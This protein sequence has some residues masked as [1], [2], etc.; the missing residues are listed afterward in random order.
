MRY[1]SWGL[2]REGFYWLWT[3]VLVIAV[4]LF[5]SINLLTLLGYVLL[6]IIALNALV[7]GRRLRSLQVR[8]RIGEPVFAQ[9][10]FAVEVQVTNL[11]RAAVVGIHIRDLGPDHA[12]GWFASRLEGRACR[13]FRQEVVLP[14]RGSYDWGPVAAVSG[15]PFGLVRR[16]LVLAPGEQVL[17][18]PRLGAL[19]RG[20]LRRYLR[21]AAVEGE[22]AHRRPQRHA[23]AQAEFHGLRPFHTGDS[24]RTIHWRTSARRG[25]LM[26]R[27]FEDSPTDNLLLVL[28]PSSPPSS[29][30]DLPSFEAA[31]S[32]AATICREWCRSTGDRLVVAL[33]GPDPVVLGG[34]AGP[35]HARRV[36]EA[37]AV[38]R[39][40]ARADPR[41]LV[42][43]LT[44]T[45]LPPAA[46]V[47]VS[48]GP[49]D[50]AGFLRQALNRPVNCLDVTALDELDFYEPPRSGG[51]VVR[52]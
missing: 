15:T 21:S 23:S 13:S 4:G 19:H 47:L 52:W 51:E 31:V 46:V 35:V 20:R 36:L 16:R 32:L 33:A 5:K 42:A 14:Q 8:R 17:V 27:E 10:P 37:L 25:E 22:R 11:G 45:P 44:A 18:L 40:G 24:P 12:L 2:P 1:S 34:S 3:A 30:F 50:L 48:V 6:A 26:V 38:Q 43:R 49:S 28:D 9:T 41:T 39:A 29:V 7:A